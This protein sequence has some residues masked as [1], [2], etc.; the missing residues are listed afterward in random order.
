M[1]F[2]KSEAE[3]NQEKINSSFLELIREINSKKE[4]YINNY[5]EAPKV[6]VMTQSEFKIV[7]EYCNGTYWGNYGHKV[8]APTILD[9]KIIVE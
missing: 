7:F 6:I 9:M 1:K 4:D 3:Y 8:E 5:G 2:F